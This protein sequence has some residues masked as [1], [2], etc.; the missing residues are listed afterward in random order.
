SAAE[1]I[2]HFRPDPARAAA[3]TP[4]PTSAPA[5]TATPAPGGGN[6]PLGETGATPPVT[7]STPGPGAPG[8]ATLRVDAEIKPR[9]VTTASRGYS[10]FLTLI[11]DPATP[12]TT[13]TIRCS[14]GTSAGC[15]PAKSK[16]TFQLRKDGKLSLRGAL[17]GRALRDGAKVEVWVT[18]PGRVGRVAR[19]KVGK[20]GRVT[21]LMR[22][23]Q[24]GATSAS[25]CG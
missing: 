9:I 13:A 17:V 4:A 11:V 6:V 5:T 16:S 8:G 20:R 24:P 12:G 18:A 7:I 23:L 15:P 21:V 19:Y 25:I 1:A 10:R 14:G 2:G 22:C 3:A